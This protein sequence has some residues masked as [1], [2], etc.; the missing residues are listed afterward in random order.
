MSH[1]PQIM[2]QTLENI[3]QP[4]AQS[5]FRS[6][7]PFESKAGQL[8]GLEVS[9][10]EEPQN[11]T[12]NQNRMSPAQKMINLQ[13]IKNRAKP[14]KPQHFRSDIMPARRKNN[15]L[16]LKLEST[17]PPMGKIFN[18]KVTKAGSS[19]QNNLSK[20]NVANFKGIRQDVAVGRLLQDLPFS[21]S[22]NN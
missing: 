4:V 21:Q 22:H 1:G 19:S 3:Q 5:R 8:I 7:Q 9:E 20:A 6:P 13:K 18:Q 17:L 16:H 15:V 11:Y 12:F 10:K 2:K 14:P